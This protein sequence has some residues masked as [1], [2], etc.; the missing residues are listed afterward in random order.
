[1]HASVLQCAVL[2]QLKVTAAPPSAAQPAPVPDR[3]V[4]VNAGQFDRQDTLVPVEL[5]GNDATRRWRLLD[6]GG[7][8]VPF[9]VDVRGRGQFVLKQLAQGARAKFRLVEDSS[10]P[11]KPPA[12]RVKVDSSKPAL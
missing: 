11:A 1:M 9:Q 4:T 12:P 8:P 2:A 5:G 6:A 3:V 10:K 7:R